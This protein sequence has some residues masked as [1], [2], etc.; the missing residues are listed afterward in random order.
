M[1]YLRQIIKNMAKKKTEEVKPNQPTEPIVD[2]PVEGDEQVEFVSETKEEEVVVSKNL[3]GEEKKVTEKFVSK[4]V[5]E[6]MTLTH[7]TVWEKVSE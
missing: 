4:K 2:L 6:P 3:A 1:F 5:F 7:R